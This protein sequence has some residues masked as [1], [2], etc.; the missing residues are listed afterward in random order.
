MKNSLLSGKSLI[1]LISFVVFFASSLHNASAQQKVVGGVDVD[2]KDYPWQVAVDYG[3]GGSIIGDSW[4]LTAAHCVGGGVNY[5]HAGNSAPYANGG[6]SYSVVNVI[7]HPLYGSGTSYSHDFALVEIEGEFN[8]SNPNIG[9]IDLISEADVLAG[10]EDA[11]V[12]ST[13]TGWGTLSSGGS[14]ASTL[15]MVQAP[16]VSNDV[17]CGATT[18]ENGNSGDYGCSSLDGSM[19]C[20]GDLIDGGEDA[21]QGDSGG[22]LVVRSLIDNR[23]LLIGATSWG[24]GCADV[25]YPGVWARVSYV[26]DWI[27][28]NADVNSEYGCMDVAACNYSDEAIYNVPEACIYEV[29]ECGD[30]GGDGPAP[31]YDCDGN[32]VT[33]ETLVIEMSDSYGDGW[34]GSNLVVNGVSVT[35][36]SGS[37]GNEV[38]CFDSTAGCNEVTVSE[39]SWPSEV[40]W[41]ISDGNGNVLLSGGAPYAGGFGAENCGPVLG[42]TDQSA[43]NYNEDAT[44]DDGSCLYPVAGCMDTL[45]LNYNPAAVED[46]GSCQYP[47]DCSD[48][49]SV[50]VEVTD[51]SWPSEVSWEL[52]DFSGGVGT[53]SACL[54]DGCISFK[55]LDSY[56]DGWN[57]STVTISSV[58]GQV[59][60]TGTL[61]SGSEGSLYFGLNYEGDC[62]PVLGCMDISSLNFNP[63]ATQDDGSCQYPISG[64]TD[65]LAL[66]FN[67]DAEVEDGS[68]YYDYDV[69]GCMDATADNYNAEATYDDG[70]CQF[71][72]PDGYVVDCDGS[73]ECHVAS[74]IGDGYADC[75]DQTWGADLSCYDNDGGDCGDFVPD[76]LGCTDSTALNFDP[77]A[78]E[79]DG[80]CQYPIDC[81]DLTAVSIDVGGGSWQSEVS[82]VVGGFAGGVGLTE[83]CLEDGCLTFTMLDSYGDGWNGNNVTITSESG[84]V[85]LTGTLESG[86]EGTLSFS[87]NFDGECGPIY[88]CT[89]QSAVNFNPDANED[90]GSCQY[91]IAGCT[92]STATNFNPEA[93]EDD[94]SC[95]YPIDCEGLT[96]VTIDVTEGGYPYEVSWELAD[97]TGST[98][99]TSACLEDGCYWF[100][101]IDSYGDGWNGSEVT[102]TTEAGVVLLIGTLDAGYEGVLSFALNDDCG[103]GPVYGCTDPTAL[104]YNENANSDDG[105]CEYDNS[106]ICPEV[107][108]PVCGANGITYSNSC[109]ADCD[110]VTYS[111]GA[112]DDEPVICDYETLTLNMLDSYGDGW[113]GNTLEVAGQS[114]TL[115]SGSE[116]TSSVCIDMSSCNTITVGGGSWQEE[117]SWTL[118]ELSGGAPFDGQIGDCGEVPGCTDELALNYNPNATVDDGSCDY[119][120]IIDYR[121]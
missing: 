38:L 70:S 71:A 73:G 11:G 48:L 101:M 79:D 107:Y 60:L 113:N 6:E 104:N 13:I 25:N 28:D 75:E 82:W 87:L 57:G 109:F 18:D 72:C 69:L 58:G 34:N 62:G 95:E 53:T 33:G 116:G 56:G 102:I 30:C 59:L 76:G 89:D 36:S 39:G 46:D 86:S 49:T 88:G 9:K 41:T 78:V 98:G 26:L 65:T 3:C 35:L 44:S 83:A 32:C 121:P 77:A 118:G 68:C 105:S 115:E 4:V 66:N 84:D 55:M 5:I 37:S 64:C 24:Y 14:M 106:C 61:D 7:T 85:L 112:C 16:I 81:S 54:E 1:K 43:L 17:A 12:M 92:D 74:W 23:W 111:E 52:G 63:L 94:G 99:S 110:G 21:C 97:L 15:Q 31:G 27:E 2:I 91:P 40:S 93:L 22:P 20:A 67:S 114:F 100:N 96:N 117:V 80:S 19:I 119:D 10:S 51:G 103:D 29:D 90:D 8:F 47:I 108:E 45:A 42:C 120:I 50:L